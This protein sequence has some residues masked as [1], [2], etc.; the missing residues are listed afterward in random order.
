MTEPGALFGSIRVLVRWADGTP[1]CGV[2]IAAE[3]EPADSLPLHRRLALTDPQGIAVAFPVPA[4][5]TRIV[6]LNGG[7]T[8]CVVDAGL[9]TDV[10]LD[11]PAGRDLIGTIVDEAGQ[12][13]AGSRILLG[14]DPRQ[15]HD[16]ALA[17]GNGVATLRSVAPDRFVAVASPFHLRSRPRSVAV[18]PGRVR[19]VLRIPGGSVTGRVID[20]TGAPIENAAVQI[21]WRGPNPD[22]ERRAPV[23]RRTDAFGHFTAI[24]L[25]LGRTQPVW[26]CA[27]G[28]A[29]QRTSV[30]TAA[31]RVAHIDIQ[32][33]PGVR[34]DGVATTLGTPIAGARVQVVDARTARLGRREHGPDFGCGS[35][36]TASD[37]SFSCD[38]LPA[39]PLEALLVLPAGSGFARAS[40]TA[41]AG[42]VLWWPA[43]ATPGEAILGRVVDGSGQ[44]LVGITVVASPAPALAVDASTTTAADGSFRIDA[45]APVPHTLAWRVPGDS[46]RPP[47]DAR[48]VATPGTPVELRLTAMS[49]PNAHVAAWPI[50]ATG[51]PVVGAGLAAF[52]SDDGVAVSRTRATGPRVGL[53]PLPAGSYEVELDHRELGI[54]SLGSVSLG[55]RQSLDLGVVQLAPPGHIEALVEDALGQPIDDWLVVTRAQG[56]LRTTIEVK[57]GTGTS[58]PL[59]PG[60]YVLHSVAANRAAMTWYCDVVAGQTATAR[61]RYDAAVEHLVRFAPTS[62]AA[63]L[64]FHGTWFAPDGAW[65]RR[66]R[67][68]WR[69]DGPLEVT[70]A[71]VPGTY[72]LELT[73]PGGTTWTETIVVPAVAGEVSVVALP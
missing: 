6:C 45:C 68:A 39:G 37:G 1:A 31:G 9:P 7:A 49:L 40:A 28:H 15:L 58:R 63:P 13:V 12:P 52:R 19:A 56:H 8:T 41:T 59:G 27:P 62:L 70:Q 66:T 51:T 38:G 57:G 48:T 55:S 16:V 43:R 72:R 64:E 61:L 3:S 50:D 71:R 23:I 73:L 60:R 36:V 11:V 46:W 44:P 10:T 25:P 42:E 47:A 24:G 2:L 20:A 26:A 33:V 34:V 14:V 53:G 32:L 21:G 22:V 4:G 18:L 17:D 67:Y 30:R 5:A 54:H 35:A 65:L 29:L 69:G